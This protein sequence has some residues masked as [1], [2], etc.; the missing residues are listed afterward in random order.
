MEQ[1]KFT[2]SDLD[3][4]NT[5]LNGYWTDCT[6]LNNSNRRKDSFKCFQDMYLMLHMFSCGKYGNDEYFYV[7]L[8]N[9]KITEKPNAQFYCMTSNEIKEKFKIDINS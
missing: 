6:D 8:E 3:V 7:I 5:D 1:K 2:D 9:V 4:W